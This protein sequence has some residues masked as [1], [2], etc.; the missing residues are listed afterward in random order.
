MELLLYFN[1]GVF[2]LIIVFSILLFFY[3]LFKDLELIEIIGRIVSVSIWLIITAILVRAF[4]AILNDTYTKLVYLMI[5]GA[6]LYSLNELFHKIF[7]P[8]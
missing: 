5:S 3:G 8:R 2:L 1:W 6:I 4:P 7:Y